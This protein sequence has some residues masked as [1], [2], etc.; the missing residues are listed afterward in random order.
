MK[1]RSRLQRWAL[2]GLLAYAIVAALILLLPV[3]YGAIVHRLTVLVQ[4]LLG[5]AW[6][7]SGWIEFAANIVLFIPMGLLL[8]LLFQ[9]AWAGAILSVVV[10][11]GVE[12][13]QIVIPHREPSVRDVIANAAGAAVGALIAWGV[14]LVARRRRR[15][16]Q[17]RASRAASV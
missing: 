3:S 17:E 8:T 12:I 1:K 16:L 6:F 9:R 14:L 2:G 15:R 7:G 5:G 13:V 11:A 10:S 4:P